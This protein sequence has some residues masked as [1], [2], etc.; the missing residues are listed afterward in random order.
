MAL[1]VFVV[2]WLIYLVSKVRARRGAV[3]VAAKFPFKS[4][5]FFVLPILTVF[6]VGFISKSYAQDE[7]ISALNSFSSDARVLVN[8]ESTENPFDI[9]AVLKKTWQVYPHHSH[10]TK[11]IDV[12]ISDESRS[13]VLRLGR[14]SDD[15][16]EYWVFYPK[17]YVTSSNEIGRVITP[18]F[19]N[20]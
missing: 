5:L 15:P 2:N 6:C 14:D 8:G 4:V 10:P 7:V 17:Y 1:P 11:R 20:N 12:Q 13:L 18:I 16:R 3:A 9:I 19:D